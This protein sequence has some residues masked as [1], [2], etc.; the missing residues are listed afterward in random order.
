[1]IKNLVVFKS[2]AAQYSWIIGLTKM[3][4]LLE[5]MPTL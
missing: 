1:M 2:Y 4:I 5:V 3:I